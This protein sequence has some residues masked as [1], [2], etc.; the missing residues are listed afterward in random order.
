MDAVCQE[1]DSHDRHHY[2]RDLEQI[3]L[4]SNSSLEGNSFYVHASLTEYPDLYTKQVNLFWC[5]KQATHKICEIGFNAGHSAMLFLLGRDESPL[6]F[7]VFD[8]GHHSYTK[9][10]LNYLQSQFQNV[11]FEYIEGDSTQTMPAWIAANPE[12]VGTYDV[13]HVDGGHSEHC[14]LNDMRNAD[15]LVNHGGIVI[16]DDTNMHHI[17][18]QV[19][20]YLESG[21]YMELPVLKTI[22]YP[23]R[24]M[25]KVVSR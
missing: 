6:N 15:V 3:I 19:D 13:V 10:C 23:H 9:P 18:R 21:N 12:H 20:V 8:I 22:G 25:R 17:N 2:L 5:G 11:N 7:T 14:I 16:V 24:I 4:D 1:Y